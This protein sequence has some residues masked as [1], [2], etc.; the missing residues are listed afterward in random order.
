MNIRVVPGWNVNVYGFLK[1]TAQIAWLTPVGEPVIPGKVFGL[2][3]GMEPS[4][5]IRSTL[6]NRL[7]SV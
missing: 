3:E 5:L 6:P 1:P 7:V 4:A 2:S